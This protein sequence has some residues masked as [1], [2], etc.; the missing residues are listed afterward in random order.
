MLNMLTISVGAST[1]VLVH[2]IGLDMLEVGG[3][4]KCEHRSILV[5]K[6]KRWRAVGVRAG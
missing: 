2:P 3:S 5:G 1:R 4:T 6:A